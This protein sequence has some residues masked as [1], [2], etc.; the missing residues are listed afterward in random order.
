[1]TGITILGKRNYNSDSNY[2]DIG[3]VGGGI[4]LEVF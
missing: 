4:V 3:R 1:M 2:C